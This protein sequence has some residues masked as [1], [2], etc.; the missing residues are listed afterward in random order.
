MVVGCIPVWHDKILMCRRAIEPQRGLWTL[1]AGF[2]E[3]GETAAEGAARETLEETGAKVVDLRPYLFFDIVH[4]QQ[5]YFMFRSRLQ[6]PHFHATRESAEVKLFAQEEI[7]WREIAFRAI[8]K[9][10]RA[11][12]QDK[13]AGVFDFRTYQIEAPNP[14]GR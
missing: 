14:D 1:P 5:M 3:N 8:E 4:I 9:T 6:K 13:P 10:L 7:P 11:Y 12:F 2:L